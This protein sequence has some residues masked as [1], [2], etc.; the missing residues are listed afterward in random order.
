MRRFLGQL[1]SVVDLSVQRQVRR[2]LLVLGGFVVAGLAVALFVDVIDVLNSLATGQEA[3]GRIVGALIVAAVGLT[4][5]MFARYHVSLR[6]M[7][8]RVQASDRA[9]KVA[10]HDHLTGLPNRRHLKG[11]LNW[12]IGENNGDQKIAVVTLDLDHFQNFNDVHGRIAGDELLQ[13]VAKLLNVRAGVEGF[14]ARLE[15]DKFVVL[16]QN[17]DE[18]ALIDWLSAL[19]TAIEAPMQVGEQEVS[20]GATVG[21][22]MAISDGRDTE[23]LLHRAELALRRAKETKRGWFAF[24]KAGMDERAHERALFENDLWTAISNDGI[25]PWFQPLVALND[26]RV[27]GYEVLA[28]WPHAE[29]GVIPPEQF[30]P[31][32][33]S[34]GMIGDLSLNVLRRACREVLNWPGQPLLSLNIS[35]VQLHDRE[36]PQQILK[37][38]SEANF[39]ASRLE[40]ELTEGALVSDLEAARKI[41]SSLKEQGVK[42]AIDNFGTGHSSLRQLRE[43]PFDKLKIDRSFIQRMTEDKDSFAMVG[44]IVA[45]AKNLELSVVAEGVQTLEQ[46]KALFALGCEQGQGDFFGKAAS[47]PDLVA[48]RNRQPAAPPAPV[49]KQQITPPTAPPLPKKEPIGV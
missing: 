36:L 16:L 15:A 45:M 22:A 38:L 35:P 4:L 41:F 30:I 19:L 18:D 20:V 49:E 37:V 42:I 47:A 3:L 6:D 31:L 46:A 14:V 10:M 39:P 43:L 24:F 17:W 11:V 23:T 33:E 7:K 27:R 5:Y 2:D 44:A 8:K 32:A 13:S 26:G 48:A 29:R 25:A 21:V 9:R 34:A 40:I 12:L 28:R 1:R